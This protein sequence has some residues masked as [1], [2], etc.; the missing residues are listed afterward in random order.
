LPRRRATLAAVGVSLLLAAPSVLIRSGVAEEPPG[1]L[2]A[3]LTDPSVLRARSVPV[4]AGL[5]GLV[6]DVSSFGL[7]P[8]LLLGWRVAPRAGAG[9]RA[10]AGSR[11]ESRRLRA[12]ALL[13]LLGMLGLMLASYLTTTMHASRHMHTSAHRLL[14][15][16]LPALTWLVVRAGGEHRH[17]AA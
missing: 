5:A 6:L 8:L 7:L 11:A 4:A 16:V 2:L 3:C 13:L 1:F 9:A 12:F 14:W 15:H 17:D 10:V